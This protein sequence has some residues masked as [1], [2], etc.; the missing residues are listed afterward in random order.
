MANYNTYQKEEAI[1]NFIFERSFWK[2]RMRGFFGYELSRASFTSPLNDSS[3]LHKDFLAGKITGYGNFL[4]PVYQAGLIYDTRDLEDDPSHGSFVEVME[5]AVPDILGSQFSYN[6][7]LIQYK[8]FNLLFPATFKKVV[9]AGWAGVNYISG[10][11]PFFEYQD[12]ESSAYTILTL[13]G[14]Q[15]LRGYVQGR[16]AAPV[17]AFAD[18][19]LR[20]RF[21]QGKLFRQHLTFSGVPFFDTGGVWDN[22]S[23]MSKLENLRYSEGLGLRIGWNENTVLRFDYAISKEDKQFFFGLQQPF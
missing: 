18:L 23:R 6:K 5:E 17:M 15:T 2:S 12:A 7:L 10:A 11:A 21:G 22:F 16:F 8:Y 1:F 14:P 4:L 13:G 3:L 19:E 9:F 20:C